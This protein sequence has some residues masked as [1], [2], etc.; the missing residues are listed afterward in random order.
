MAKTRLELV[1]ILSPFL[2]SFT[3]SKKG[4]KKGWPFLPPQKAFTLRMMPE[5]K[6]GRMRIAIY[7][8]YL[9]AVL[10]VR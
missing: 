3:K 7:C 10:P 4:W 2:R 6:K 9:M 5:K 8:R 1:L